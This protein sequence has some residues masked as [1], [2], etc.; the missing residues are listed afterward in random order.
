M[1]YYP[2]DKTS[3]ICVVERFTVKLPTSAFL[4]VVFVSLL[5][6]RLLAQVSPGVQEIDGI[7]ENQ[8]VTTYETAPNTAV[9]IVHT[10]AEEKPVSLDR[11]ARVDVTNLG[12]HRGVFLIVPGRDSAVFANT[13]LGKYTISVTAVGYMSASQDN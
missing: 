5:S 8:R 6:M 10:F 13:A 11:S 2:D 9:I 3:I 1:V 7:R 12:N 4:S